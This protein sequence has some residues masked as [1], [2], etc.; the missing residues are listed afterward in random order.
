M[1][2]KNRLFFA[3]PLLLLAGIHA[4]CASTWPIEPVDEDHPIGNTMGEFI[5]TI[6]GAYQHEGIDVLGDSY[7]ERPDAPFVVVTVAGKVESVMMNPDS[8]DNYVLILGE[9][10]DR[11]YLYAHL[12]F[13]T[14][15]IPIILHVNNTP[16][17]AGNTP[18]ENLDREESW[19]ILKEGAK[20]AKLSNL[21]PCEFDHVH[22]AVQRVN[23][24]ASL[25]LVNP[26]LEIRPAPDSSQ[27][28]IAGIHLAQHDGTR[29]SEIP[30]NPDSGQCTAV[31]GEIDIIVEVIDRDDAGSTQMGA[32]NVGLHTLRWR[33]CKNMT[34]SWKDT[35]TFDEMK[36]DWTNPNNSETSIH[37]STDDPWKSTFDFCAGTP[38]NRTFMVPT[39]FAV[40]GSWKT[41]DGGVSNGEYELMVQAKDI[42][43]NK[44]TDSIKV[45]VSNPV[46]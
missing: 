22:Y 5:E 20:I 39:S 44:A 11:R 29:W 26:L 27:P 18:D 1:S 3:G 23:D 12:E 25:T 33:A 30:K 38:G 17:P 34:C 10:G 14:I 21:F 31:K 2:A 40:A 8:R 4:A 28:E 32:N 16:S 9:N 15:P 36:P 35:H 45:C 46:D 13:T 43:G 41:D 6:E 24:D 37:Y 42:A 7:D 19:P